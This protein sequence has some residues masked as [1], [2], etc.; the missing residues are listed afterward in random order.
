MYTVI[1]NMKYEIIE[2]K[3]FKNRLLGLMFKKKKIDKIYLFKNCNNI[4]TCFMLQNIDICMTD[5]NN[6]IIYLKENVK[7]FR[8]IIK[9]KAKNTYEMPLNTVKLLKLNQDFITKK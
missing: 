5:K 6:K 4:H 1:N 3:T 8:I 9:L 2:Q 7:P